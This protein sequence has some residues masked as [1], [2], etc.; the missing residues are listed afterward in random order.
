MRDQKQRA[1]QELIGDR[2]EVLAEH[3]LLVQTA[4]EQP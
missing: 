3:R 1:Q 4:R 2:I